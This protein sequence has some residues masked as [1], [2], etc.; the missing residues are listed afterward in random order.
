MVFLVSTFAE[1]TLTDL[2]GRVLA[3]GLTNFDLGQEFSID[4][5]NSSE[6]LGAAI[7]AGDLVAIDSQGNTI[8]SSSDLATANIPQTTDELPEGLTRLYFTESRARN[9][10]SIDP[11]STNFLGYNP[12]TGQISIDNLAITDVT[13]DNTSTDLADFITSNYTGTEFQEGDTII[14]T[15]PSAGGTLSYMHNGGTAGTV[16]DF[17]ELNNP[18][19][20]TDEAA[21]R[22]LFSA[23]APLQYNNTTGNFSIPEADNATDGFL[24]AVDWVTFN[25]KQAALSAGDGISLAGNTA[26]V[27]IAS[28]GGLGFNAGEIEIGTDAIDDTKINFG[29][30]GSQVNA[31]DLPIIDSGN[32][33]SGSNVEAALAELAS[34]VGNSVTSVNGETGAVILD[35]GDIA[36]NG[37]LYYTQARFD[38]AFV[39]KDTD[40]L[41]EGT[42]NL[43]Y[44]QT[45]FNNAFTTKTTSDLSEGTNLYF[46]N[47]RADARIAAASIND[48][49]DVT[50]N[51]PSDNQTLLFSGGNLVNASITAGIVGVTAGSFS[52]VLSATDTDVQT[53]LATIDGLEA[54]SVPL[55]AGSTYAGTA[56]NVEDALE[57]TY[58]LAA[59]KTFNLEMGDS[60]KVRDRFLQKPSGVFSNVSPFVVYSN[61]TLTNYSFRS[62]NSITWDLEIY[63]NGTVAQTINVSSTNKGFGSLNITLNAGDEISIRVA[64]GVQVE[65]PTVSLLF[66]ER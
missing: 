24:S 46:T 66:T 57:E 4:E 15:N 32:N 59:L 42:T 16:A 35:T 8:S 2:G 51:T 28:G 7:D 39:A 64:G 14:L 1:V 12:S 60:G 43:Y 20:S 56:T 49:S 25:S 21:I 38:T 22:A 30:V 65:N 33:F 3:N 41:G 53:A 44:T 29:T 52:G 47:S 19:S 5:L 61:S 13:V 37:N 48:L 6:D 9:S 58:D 63:V 10:I 55:S 31:S 23:T 18:L 34:G 36:E 54:L 27:R 45:R 50:I 26:S 40:D 11:G 17:T 62:S